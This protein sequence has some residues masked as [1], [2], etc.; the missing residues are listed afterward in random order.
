MVIMY[1]DIYILWC[2]MPERYACHF[3]TLIL[4]STFIFG[5]VLTCHPHVFSI[6]TSC[7][8][9][10]C[11]QLINGQ[12]IAD[13]ITTSSL[14]GADTFRRV[15]PSQTLNLARLRLSNCRSLDNAA[16]WGLL[17]KWVR[18][19]SLRGWRRATTNY[20]IYRVLGLRI[21]LKLSIY[22]KFNINM[23]CL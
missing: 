20:V 8:T 9:N 2:K 17:V 15:T 19:P 14:S 6:F 12:F 13:P 11:Y 4:I 16:L 7:S 3:Y 5:C 23:V 1:Y 18:P 21:C 22:N 10:N